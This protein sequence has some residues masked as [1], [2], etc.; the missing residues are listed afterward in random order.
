[1]VLKINVSRV[2][3]IRQQYHLIS[4]WGGNEALNLE[5][6]N[7]VLNLQSQMLLCPQCCLSPI[8]HSHLRQNS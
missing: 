7:A 3:G 2:P 4:R 6:L 5:L 1:M 8:S